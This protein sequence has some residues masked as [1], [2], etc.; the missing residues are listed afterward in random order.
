MHPEQVGRFRIE[1]VLGHGGNGV[2]YRA[3][4]TRDGTPVALKTVPPELAA[5][6]TL[7][8]LRREATVLARL[9][10]PSIAKLLEVTTVDGRI[11]LVL[12]HVA[13]DTLRSLLAAGPLA[14]PELLRLAQET[15]AGLAAA[16]ANGV[17][18]RDLKP[19]NVVV[20]GDRRA[21]IL[22]FGLA[23]LLDPDRRQESTLTAAGERPGTLSAM[24]PEQVTG[25]AYDHRSDLFALGATMYEMATGRHPF[26][27]ATPPEVIHRICFHEP[28]A[29]TAGGLSAGAADLVH[30]LLAK[31]PGRRPESAAAVVLELARLRGVPPPVPPPPRP[32][33]TLVRIR[34]QGLGA[35]LGAALRALWR[36]PR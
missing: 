8:R 24:S 20:T 6:R 10:H 12:E 35:R 21:V 17:I 3:V 7:R 26:Q 32:R 13:G 18:H 33:G 16:H 11:V 4:D 31:R 29:A 5:G 22:D 34:R 36:S 14:E 23:K 9:R 28:P 2:V 30:R 25:A 27:A 19:E 1:S 15:A